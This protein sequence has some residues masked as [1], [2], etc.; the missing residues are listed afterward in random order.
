MKIL[1]GILR[2]DAGSLSFDGAPLALVGPG[3]AAPWHRVVHQELSLFPERSVLANLFANAEP[4][5]YG[6]VSLREMDA[7]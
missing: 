6:L 7:A 1:G 2:P 4:S 3:G 5:R